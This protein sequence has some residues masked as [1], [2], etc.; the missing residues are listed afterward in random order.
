MTSSVRLTYIKFLFQ[1]QE[2]WDNTNHIIL[3]YFVRMQ[4]ILKVTTAIGFPPHPQFYLFSERLQ[5]TLKKSIKKTR[6][7]W[8]FTKFTDVRILEFLSNFIFFIINQSTYTQQ[9]FR[10]P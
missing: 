4:I 5:S 6:L 7:T 9:L 8:A 2:G 3:N 1:V 10:E